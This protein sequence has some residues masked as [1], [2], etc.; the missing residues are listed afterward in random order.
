MRDLRATTNSATPRL[1]RGYQAA[2]LSAL[3]VGVFALAGCT[4]THRDPL[5]SA[6]RGRSYYVDGA[7]GGGVFTDRAIGVQT[8][9]ARAGFTGAY[10]E[11]T[12]QTGLGPLLDQ[13]ASVRYKRRKAAQLAE[14]IQRERSTRPA[15]PLQLMGFSAGTAVVV[16]ALEML[17]P[18][19]TV[20]NVVLVGSSLTSRYDLRAGL[21]HVRRRVYIYV[22]PRDAILSWLAPLTGSA[23]RVYCGRALM[24][25]CGCEIPWSQP[26]GPR[27]YRKIE[28]IE[29]TPEF[30]RAGHTGGHTES[31]S[32]EFVRAYIA[33]RV[34]W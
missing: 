24:G 12:W 2:W 30:A 20:D 29:W 27:L 4:T 31:V 25:L 5:G 6:E 8:G 33:P 26:D 14:L 34:S 28:T 16:Y 17:P 15:A 21:Q 13:I 10:S 32:P 1:A 3:L 23:D 7:G 19:C 22:S 18:G 9:L 11:F